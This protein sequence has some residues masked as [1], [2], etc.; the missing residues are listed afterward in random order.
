ML[1]R[2]LYVFVVVTVIAS[3]TTTPEVPENPFDD[4]SLGV[5]TDSIEAAT[6][7]TLT[8]DPNSLAGLHKNV[9]KPSCANAGCHDGTFEPDFRTIQSSYNTLVNQTVIKLDTPNVS[10]N[11]RLVPSDPDA[12][13]VFYRVAYSG[14]DEIL[15]PMP[16]EASLMDND[17]MLNKETYIQNLRTWIENGAPNVSD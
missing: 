3:C 14:L 4:P 15:Y 1:Y 12:S 6:A 13:M 9:F 7:D 11:K 10:I 5:P 17:W 2:F 16:I 8:L